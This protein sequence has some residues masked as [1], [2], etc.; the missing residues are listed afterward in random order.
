MSDKFKNLKVH[1][2]GIS[3][4]GMSATAIMLKSL[5]A[6]VTGSD[7]G[8]YDPVASYLKKHN[9]LVLTPHRKRNIPRDAD[10]I[11]VGR[12]AKLDPKENEEVEAAIES[13]I[14]LKSFPELLGDI[15]EEKEN[16]VV[17]G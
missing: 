12:H 4:A 15:T 3:G 10:L 1:F 16:I 7:E 8:F 14:P 6:W 9:I 17:A 13:K 5:G 2:I 11:I